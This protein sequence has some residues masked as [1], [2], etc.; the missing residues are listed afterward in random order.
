MGDTLF[1]KRAGVVLKKNPNNLSHISSDFDWAGLSLEDISKLLGAPLIDKDSTVDLPDNPDLRVMLEKVNARLQDLLNQDMAYDCLQFVTTLECPNGQRFIQVSAGVNFYLGHYETAAKLAGVLGDV[2]FSYNQAETAH[3]SFH[4]NKLAGIAY[5]ELNDI[6]NACHYFQQC[7]NSNG[8]TKD[9]NELAAML[10]ILI[11]NKFLIVDFGL[12]NQLKYIIENE[13]G[14]KL[15][16]RY[17]QLLD[18]VTALYIRPKKQS[19][20]LKRGKEFRD[21]AANNAVT[22]ANELFAKYLPTQCFSNAQEILEHLSKL[23]S[24]LINLRDLMMASVNE[25]SLE[26]QYDYNLSAYK[27]ALSLL[28]KDLIESMSLKDIL[29][30]IQLEH[31]SSNEVSQLFRKHVNIIASKIKNYDDFLSLAH[32]PMGSR[33]CGKILIAKTTGDVLE[34]LFKIIYPHIDEI[35]NDL[36]SGNSLSLWLS[37]DKLKKEGVEAF[38][39]KRELPANNNNTFFTQ[40]VAVLSSKDSNDVTMHDQENSDPQSQSQ[41]K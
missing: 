27:T 5:F 11:E 14:S 34:H 35:R 8:C 37:L 2:Y 22:G 25:K 20:E 1:Q 13:K 39:E 33:N 26:L 23:R 15:E 28:D 19:D 7:I 17:S 29:A 41:F 21:I 4:F 12:I 40:P 31:S 16:E 6:E 9:W 32:Y 30:F 18:K 10:D 24:K 3:K 38:E 36:L